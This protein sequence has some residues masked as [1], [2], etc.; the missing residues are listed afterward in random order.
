[1][2]KLKYLLLLLFIFP[3]VVYGSE[4]RR[5]LI[6]VT[7]HADGTASF[8]ETWEVPQQNDSYFQKDFFNVKGMEISN[9]KIVNKS[10]LEYKYVNRLNKD[11]RKTFSRTKHERSV[12]YNIVLDT[13]KDD[14]YTITYD[15]D[16]MIKK[17]NDNT[18]GIDYTFIGINYSMKINSVLIKITSEV[19]LMETNTALY[20]LG[21]DLVLNLTDGVI[22][23]NTYTYDN[24]STVRLF[25]KFTDLTFDKYIKV[26]S[27]FQETYD[28]AKNQNAYVAY[29]LNIISM[30][31]FVILV[32]IVVL[33]IGSIITITIIN[34]KKSKKEFNGIDT[35][36]NKTIPTLEE[37]DYYKD[38]SIY[39]LYKAGFLASYFNISKNRS[40]LVG[41]FLLKWMYD[42]IVDVFPKDNKPFIRLN[43]D[44][45][46]DD[47]QLDKDLYG[48]L[49]ESSSHNIIDGS[50]LERFSNNHYLRV[51]TW[52]NMGVSNVI[53]EAVMVNSVKRINK[54]NKVH[55]ELQDQMIAEA[56]NLQGLKKYL[57]NFNQ[58]PRETEL[59]ENTYKY[60]L[61]YAELFGIGTQV[62][63]EILRKNPDNI[64]AQKLLDLDGVRF[65]YKNFYAKAYDRY[66]LLN[67]NNL[68]DIS[69]IDTEIDE[70]LRRNS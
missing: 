6:D 67:K 29:I 13:Y 62:A 37:A 54:G 55:L 20:G 33:L 52:Y 5:D 23:L 35:Y 2:K 7:I 4:I 10:G 45:L 21:K 49:K 34:K 38:I 9:F 15:V 61:I 44:T 42:G 27:T 30:R 8:T 22:N 17:Y 26:D 11:E 51:M 69:T 58:V 64:Y 59:T 32:V 36:M 28:K 65:L 60:L 16:G 56:K 18:Y 12:S 53:N 3:C 46:M 47:I 68:S 14:V 24:K 70:I 63:K 57:L 19:P 1:M 43:H 50:K 66:K 31:T 39:D 41:A 25:T 40:D 48:M